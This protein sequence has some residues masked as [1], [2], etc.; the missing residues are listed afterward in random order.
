VRFEFLTA[1]CTKIVSAHVMQYSTVWGTNISEE[2]SAFILRK[3][4]S[5]IRKVT[6]IRRTLKKT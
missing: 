4:M 6:E 1:V 2:H 5:L 3:G